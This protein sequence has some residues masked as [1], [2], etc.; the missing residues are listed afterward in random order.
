MSDLEHKLDNTTPLRTPHTTN[1]FD[2]DEENSD[3]TE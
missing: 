1:L 3:R 2:C